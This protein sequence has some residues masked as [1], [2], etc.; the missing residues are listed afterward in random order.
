[1]SVISWAGVTDMRFH[2]AGFA[3]GSDGD[4]WIGSIATAEPRSRSKTCSQQ[5]AMD[6]VESTESRIK[7]SWRS[8]NISETHIH[9][10]AS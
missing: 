1:M 2:T 3:R 7:R 10:D 5:N 6:V 4:C 8:S 9:H